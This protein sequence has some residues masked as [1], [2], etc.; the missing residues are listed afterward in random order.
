MNG[1][2]FVELIKTESRDFTIDWA[3]GNRSG[4]SAKV[5]TWLSN[6]PE[7]QKLLLKEVITEAL[8]TSI[9]QVLEIMDGV[10]SKNSTPIEASSSNEAICGK[11]M[12]Q[13]HDLYANKIFFSTICS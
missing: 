13:L 4:V 11:G 7:E 12:P 5:N 1:E 8:D 9:F 2:K 3:L 6:L 10:H